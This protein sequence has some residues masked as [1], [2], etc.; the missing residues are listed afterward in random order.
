MKKILVTLAAVAAC[1]TLATPA[2]AGSKAAAPKT[3]AAAAIPV[4]REKAMTHLK[5]HVDYPADRAKILAACADTEEF[6]KEQ[7]D[8]FAKHLPEGTYASADDVA[9]AL[10]I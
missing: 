10:G 6:T 9:K 2:F 7:K 4:D 3:K 1:A 5:N 8:W